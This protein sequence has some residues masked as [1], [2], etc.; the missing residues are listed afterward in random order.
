MNH[1]R[2]VC[3]RDDEPSQER[4]WGPVTNVTKLVRWVRGFTMFCGLA[5]CLY[6]GTLM[7]CFSLPLGAVL[8]FPSFD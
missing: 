5:L 7:R 4:P 3:S 6:V 8:C 2:Y 1:G